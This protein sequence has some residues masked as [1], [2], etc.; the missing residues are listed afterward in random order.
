EHITITQRNPHSLLQTHAAL[1]DVGR[2]LLLGQ[3]LCAGRLEQRVRLLLH[4]LHAG[5]ALPLELLIALPLLQQ[6]R[7]AAQRHAQLLLQAGPP[8]TH[9]HTHTHA[10]TRT[11]TH[12]HT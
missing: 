10:Q 9:T 11:R 8:D 1:V 5:A 12:T 2:H 6:G 4:S 7:T 3:L